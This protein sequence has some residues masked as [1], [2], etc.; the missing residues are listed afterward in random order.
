M[1][2]L[3]FETSRQININPLLVDSPKSFNLRFLSKK[4][5]YLLKKE[6]A[7]STLPAQIADKKIYNLN[8]HQ[9]P[10]QRIERINHKNGFYTVVLISPNKTKSYA[11]DALKSP[12]VPLLKRLEGLL[13][14]NKSYL[15][16]LEGEPSE[17]M[18]AL[19]LSNTQVTL[20]ELQ[21]FFTKFPNL[22]SLNLAGT[23]LNWENFKIPANCKIVNLT[24]TSVTS[25][26]AA[27][28][29]KDLMLQDLIL[30][31]CPN[32]LPIEYA[33]I[34]YTIAIK[35]NPEKPNLDFLNQVDP[36]FKEKFLQS[37]SKFRL[38]KK[39]I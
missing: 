20:D 12:V 10:F 21:V 19:D 25:A 36:V 38:P 1:N 32:V 7:A 31:N 39:I 22:R 26:Q 34:R 35:L 4:L 15:N 2:F 14:E 27:R 24:G 16:L 33:M 13:N 28:Y 8:F 11:I 29:Q 17:E 23:N 37:M 30:D 5:D 6:V 9:S 3:S 18:S